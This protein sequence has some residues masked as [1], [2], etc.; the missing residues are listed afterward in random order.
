MKSVKNLREVIMFGK[1]LSAGLVVAGYA[2][3][4]VWVCNWLNTEGWPLLVSLGAIPVITGFGMWQAW[5][6]VTKKFPLN[7]KHDSEGK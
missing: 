3:L 1:V 6:F 7:R 5:L 2:F 4:G